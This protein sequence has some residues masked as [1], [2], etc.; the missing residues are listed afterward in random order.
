MKVSQ[1]AQLGSI[2]RQMGR[3]A[4]STQLLAP[5]RNTSITLAI[6]DALLHVPDMEF[7]SAS[8]IRTRSRLVR[9]LSSTLQAM[10]VCEATHPQPRSHRFCCSNCPLIRV[11]FV[12]S[13]VG[14]IPVEPSV[15]QSRRQRFDWRPILR[16]YAHLSRTERPTDATAHTRYNHRSIPLS[17]RS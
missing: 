17:Q 9:R 14:G 2:L 13:L 6:V 3:V 4:A 5:H 8:V 1:L 10:Q 12:L 16:I 7:S 11:G 15:A